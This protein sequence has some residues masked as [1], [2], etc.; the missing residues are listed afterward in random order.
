MKHPN[1]P[2]LIVESKAKA[3][4][5]VEVD[6]KKVIYGWVEVPE[7]WTLVKYDWSRVP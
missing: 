7:G 3:L 5:M 2:M 4:V 1:A 6:G